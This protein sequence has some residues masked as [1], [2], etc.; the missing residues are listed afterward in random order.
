[1]LAIVSMALLLTACS[2]DEDDNNRN[3]PTL[4][5]RTVVVYMS[6]ENNLSTFL[7]KDLAEIRKGAQLISNDNN[8]VVYVDTPAR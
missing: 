8:L 5:G 1:M 3:I 4:A 6:G 2:K 7:N